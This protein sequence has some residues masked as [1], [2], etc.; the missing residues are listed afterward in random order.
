M[1]RSWA[2]YRPATTLTTTTPKASTDAP[3]LSQPNPTVATTSPAT[4]PQPAAVNPVIMSTVP[5][6]RGRCRVG[7]AATSRVDD[8]TEP[9]DQPSPRRNRPTPRPGLAPGADSPDRTSELSRISPPIPMTS[10]L[11][12]RSARIP[13]SGENANMPRM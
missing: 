10:G 2:A 4:A 11:P 1:L 3:A 13:T 9:N 8:P 7:V 6:T 12:A 5:W